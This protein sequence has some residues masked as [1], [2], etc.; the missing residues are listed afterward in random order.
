MLTPPYHKFSFVVI[1]GATNHGVVLQHIQRLDDFP[2]AQR[3]IFNLILG[4]MIKDAIK[5][6]PY[7]RCQFDVRQFLGDR[8]QVV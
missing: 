8:L 5:I 4:E 7:F 1:C 2:N 6:I 3:R